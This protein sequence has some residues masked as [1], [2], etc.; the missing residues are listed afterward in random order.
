[1]AQALSLCMEIVSHEKRFTVR[2]IF[3][4]LLISL[5]KFWKY[6]YRLQYKNYTWSIIWNSSAVTHNLYWS[7]TY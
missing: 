1:M 6:F 2:A 3:L 4:A 7:P 5:L